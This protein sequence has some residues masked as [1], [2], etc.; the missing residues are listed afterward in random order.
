[1]APPDRD[2]RP[3]DTT[4][5]NTAGIPT[6]SR[7]RPNAEKLTSWLEW[8]LH[9]EEHDY[10]RTV[11]YPPNGEKREE[12]GRRYETGTTADPKG[13]EL[14]FESVIEGWLAVDFLRAMSVVATQEVER[15]S[16]LLAIGT[17]ALYNLWWL[18][19]DGM[20]G[21][22]GSFPSTW[23]GPASSAANDSLDRI[24]N[25]ADQ[26][27]KIAQDL[28]LIPAKYA[29]VIMGLR[30]NANNAAGQL[31]EA[32]E[33]RFAEHNDVGLDIV[34]ILVGAIAAASFTYLT[35]GAA[36]LVVESAVG[37]AWSGTL[38]GAVGALKGDAGRIDGNGWRELAQ[39]Y[40]S[41]QDDMLTEAKQTMDLLNGEVARLLSL[42]KNHG[43]TNE[44]LAEH[45]V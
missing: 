19:N 3:R 34:G 16:S 1:M 22:T 6:D 35:G 37:S 32:F 20:Q 13:N 14:P 44:F 43:P 40:L 26:V 7:M 31:V 30:D 11:I 23:S 21:L 15:E 12:P 33:H 10:D 2:D 24:A 29:A 17:A 8:L 42:L 5:L 25:I 38:S 4:P 28:R 27:G 9:P 41:A 45:G 36:G 18:G 39:S